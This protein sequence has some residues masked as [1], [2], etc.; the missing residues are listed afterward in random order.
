MFYYFFR[1]FIPRRGYNGQK[2]MKLVTKNMTAIIIRIIATV[3]LITFVKKSK[4]T[5][6]AT[7]MR[8]VLSTVP[9]FFFIF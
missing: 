4:A 7:K 5:I 8:I 2:L 3:P 6:A 9:M 1:V